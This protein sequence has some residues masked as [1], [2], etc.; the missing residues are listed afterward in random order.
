MAD[1]LK[2]RSIKTLKQ[3]RE[4]IRNGTGKRYSKT[5]SVDDKKKSVTNKM[6]GAAIEH[7][8]RAHV[9]KRKSMDWGFVACIDAESCASA[10]AANQALT[11]AG[12]DPSADRILA[13]NFGP[14]ECIA[15]MRTNVEDNGIATV[16][17]VWLLCF[18]CHTH[19]HTCTH[20]HAR[21]TNTGMLGSSNHMHA[22][23][24]RQFAR[25]VH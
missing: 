1:T 17:P 11:N 6:W 16:L 25:R 22:I 12:L 19:A 14:P 2:P 4:R 23:F 5:V 9:E 8:A 18:C 13:V 21:I 10:T 7:L 3:L 15:R 20:A 24:T